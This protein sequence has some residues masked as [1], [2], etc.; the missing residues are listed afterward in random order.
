[1]AIGKNGTNIQRADKLRAGDRVY[2]PT[3]QREVTVRATTVSLEPA[4]W[5]V[6]GLLLTGKHPVKKDLAAAWVLPA[7]I[8]E[9]EWLSRPMPVYNFVVSEGGTMLVNDLIVLTLGEDFEGSDGLWSPWAQ[10]FFGTSKVV[11]ALR[12]LPSWPNCNLTGINVD[13]AY[14]KWKT[15]EGSQKQPL[16]GSTT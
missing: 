8:A 5:S 1:V 4:M 11:D 12:L 14:G 7:N 16:T 2:S 10:D 9:V 6:N 13:E 15:V 3:L